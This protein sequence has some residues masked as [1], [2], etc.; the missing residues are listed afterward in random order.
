MLERSIQ[1][2]IGVSLVVLTLVCGCANSPTDPQNRVEVLREGHLP[3]RQFSEVG[4]LSDSGALREQGVI[5]AK[6]LKLAKRLGADAVIFDLPI[7]EG[8]E[9][10]G[11][12]WV[13][14]YLFRARAIV[15][16]P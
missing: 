16:T 9:L 5:E 8:G 4:M 13:Q 6:M 15:Y 12:S 2:R 7:Q 3:N 1:L 11:F 10:Q 14:T